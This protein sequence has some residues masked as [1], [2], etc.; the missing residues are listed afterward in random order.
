MI[1]KQNVTDFADYCRKTLDLPNAK[2][3]CANLYVNLPQ[4][5]CDAIFSMGA[6]Y[7][8][9]RKVVANYVSYNVAKNSS[10]NHTISEFLETIEKVGGAEKFASD[11]VKNLQRTSAVN[12]ILKAESCRLVALELK[13]R[14]IETISDFNSYPDREELDRAILSTRSNKSGI[15]LKYLYMLTGD[16]NM[17][18]PDRMISRYIASAGI[19]V[20]DNDEKVE[21]VRAAAAELK[22]EFPNLVPRAL[23]HAIWKYQ[24][25]L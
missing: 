2:D 16:E 18:K 15:M 1:T 12:G 19:S 21:L 4:A 3:P 8:S 22:S 17:V 6:R 5:L 9:V 14:G 23:D 10:P 20:L 11:I 25:A 24:R 7:G 13:A